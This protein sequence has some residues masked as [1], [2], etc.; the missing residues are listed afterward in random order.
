M[1]NRWLEQP[2]FIDHDNA[3]TRSVTWMEL[4]FDLVF[5]GAFLQFENGFARDLLTRFVWGHAAAFVPILLIWTGY[6]FYA[7]RFSS[8]DFLHRA[9]ILLCM[10]S[11]GAMSLSQQAVTQG[12]FEAYCRAAAV[13]H[14]CIAGLYSRSALQK[15]LSKNPARYWG[16]IFGLASALWLSASFLPAGYNF[17]T[18]LAAGLLVLFSPLARRSSQD[19]STA[20]YDWTH[21]S[22]RYG[23]LTIIALGGG[24]IG[25]LAQLNLSSGHL[26]V[27]FG[28]AVAFTIIASV[29]WMYFDDVAG[30]TI[31]SQ[32]S[33]WVIWVYSHIPLLVGIAGLVAGLHILEEIN[34][35]EPAVERQ[36]WQLA[37]SLSMIYLAIAAID[38]VTERRQAELSDSL[39]INVRL[40][41]GLG[42]LIIAPS[43]SLI[44][45]GAFVLLIT[46]VG[47][48]Q[49]VFDLLLTPRDS[50][51]EE[52]AGISIAEL[53]RDKQLGQPS[54]NLPTV[55]VSQAIRKGAP[56]SLRHDLYSYFLG[57]SW[58][59]LLFA[60][61]SVFVVANLFFG[62]LY[63]L[64]P[65]GISD[66][67]YTDF[68]DAFF[69][70]VQ[71]MSTIGYGTM[72]PSS[73][74]ANALVA[75]EAAVSTVGIAAV[76]GL[77]FAKI[78]RVKSGVLFSEVMTLTPFHG[79]PT[80]ML[81]L[82]NA[83]GHEIVDAQVQVMLL[84][85]QISPEGQHLRRLFS[86][87]LQRSHNPLF[88]LG[89]TVM[90]IIDEQSPLY[91]ELEQG[92]LSEPSIFTVTMTGHDGTYGAT[93]YARHTYSGA[94]IRKGHRFV[95]IITQL[96]DGRMMID[97]DRFHDTEEI[98]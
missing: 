75:V 64:E 71:T 62:A 80:L 32:R 43:G 5:V 1:R 94:H 89:W 20:S 29:W 57:G 46:S 78:S 76:T 25:I 90:H 72:S 15:G 42:L 6:T 10:A 69:F 83:R 68:A 70:S 65:N 85:D 51:S 53:T 59:R 23:L 38:S 87:K 14:L 92:I 84:K 30:A 22:F 95:D 77:V 35:Q 66:G 12:H 52:A 48:A 67:K 41:S 44:S 39:R 9:L 34:F 86:L 18:M 24:M 91:G 61:G 81:R 4:F 79:Q 98:A 17:A 26:S 63:L 45:G 93:T 28:G 19:I 56:S 50:S 2:F 36:R 40:F 55:D 31:R 3:G 27:Y 88:A 21:L 97:Y 8:D 11:V 47:I 96:P 60:F 58:T 13:A 16:S 7:N 54:P 49:I 74:Y 33:R 82:G 37:G 73:D